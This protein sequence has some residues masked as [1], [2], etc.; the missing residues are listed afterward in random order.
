VA[1]VF[2]FITAFAAAVSAQIVSHHANAAR[3]IIAAQASAVGLM[4][5]RINTN[6]A[7]AMGSAVGAAEL[8]RTRGG[9]GADPDSVADAATHGGP[10][11]AA[12]VVTRQGDIEAITDEAYRPIVLGALR[13]AGSAGV[14]AGAPDM[15][16]SATAPV[17]VRHVGDRAVVSVLD[18]ARLLP[19]LGGDARVLISTAN[20][21]PL[22]MSPALQ[23]AGARA[24]Q[25]LIAAVRDGG[26]G[27][28]A[29]DS[30]GDSWVAA[31]AIAQVGAFR[32]VAASPAP[33]Q[34]TLWLE[35]LGR[36]ALLAA[37]PL[38]A[39]GVLYLLMRQHAQRARLFQ[40]EANRAEAHFRIAADGARVGVME[41][42]PA[43]RVGLARVPG[44]DRQ[45]GP[46]VR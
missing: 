12:A 26:S 6:L 18:P 14:W 9:V 43:R 11:A 4:A 46:P 30:L 22:Y 29:R 38:A 15:G 33:S 7:V 10:A 17:I 36:F 20:G 5:E 8:A 44:S 27:G 2:V 31:E 34:A 45:R 41:W 24:Q 23:A 3:T 16:E 1:L 19:E 28:F 21:A 25:Q 39:M 13:A 40:A 32:V 37:A 42:R 35:A